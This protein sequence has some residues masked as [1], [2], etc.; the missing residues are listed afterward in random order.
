M[1]FLNKLNL[2]DI[3]SSN[4][5]TSDELKED[6]YTQNGFK[7]G[8]Y[9]KSQLFN[10]LLREITL[11]TTALIESIEKHASSAN[12]TVD[13]NTNRTE[14]ADKI[15]Y[16]LTSN[17]TT[18]D[19]LI[20]YLGNDT[21]IFAFDGSAEQVLAFDEELFSINNTTKKLGVSNS[22]FGNKVF[23][24]NDAGITKNIDLSEYGTIPDNNFNM[25]IKFTTYGT[26]TPQY[27]ELKLGNNNSQIFDICIKNKLLNTIF[28]NK[29]DNFWNDN[30]IIEFNI[31]LTSEKANIIKNISS[32]MSYTNIDDSMIDT[33]ENTYL[34]YLDRSGNQSWKDIDTITVGNAVNATNANLAK[35]ATN[36]S[37]STSYIKYVFTS[38][39]DYIELNSGIYLIQ[40][41]LN[42]NN[43]KYMY[44]D[45]MS[46]ETTATDLNHIYYG[47][48]HN[49][50]KPDE[51]AKF[52][53]IQ[54]VG[55]QA[56][57]ENAIKVAIKYFILD[58]LTPESS[59]IMDIDPDLPAVKTFAGS[60]INYKLLK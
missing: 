22:Y 23:L 12:F 3:N 13:A 51:T 11:V 20:L 36:S 60:T 14:L 57:G 49:I 40:Y 27:L 33:G 1:P 24:C 17:T 18:Q 45:I 32:C 2:W 50:R 21:E 43:K 42:I 55:T 10:T 35:I 54:L 15:Y 53:G 19:S 29:L 6:S 46:L 34:Y 48:R 39:T 8:D 4:L 16:T 56:A 25:I 37:L 38:N 26:A 7:K 30:D 9:L 31:D 5:I 59:W 47:T 52:Y 58:T 44:T 41:E 28:P